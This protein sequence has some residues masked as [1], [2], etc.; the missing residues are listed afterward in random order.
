M[1]GWM[2]VGYA[3]MDARMAGHRNSKCNINE[4]LEETSHLGL[5]P[6]TPLQRSIRIKVDNLG[7]KLN[8]PC[9]VIQSSN[10]P[11]LQCCVVMTTWIRNSISCLSSR[12]HLTQKL[13][14]WRILFVKKKVNQ[15][16]KRAITVEFFCT[17]PVF[18]N[19]YAILSYSILS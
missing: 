2:Y 1:D 9:T 15:S 5:W 18:S 16:S 13:F 7:H 11:R 8:S 19:D 17:F 12:V 14:M 10:C 6:L 4:G 3:Y